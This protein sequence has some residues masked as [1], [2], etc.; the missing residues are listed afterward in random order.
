MKIVVMALAGLLL[1]AQDV[2]KVESSFDKKMNFAGLRTYSWSS[3]YNAYNPEAHKLVVAAFETEMTNLGFSKVASGG[4][5]TLA[6]YTVVGSDVDLKALDKM[7]RE[8]KSG[9]APTKARARLVVIMRGAASR[10]Q[11]WSASTREYVDP[12]PAALSAAI[13]SVT[14][15]LFATYPGRKKGA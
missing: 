9:L 3:G 14:A 8:G 4:D 10:E 13:Q 12:D 11:I 5:V 15:R 2:G 1:A 6:Y 7:E